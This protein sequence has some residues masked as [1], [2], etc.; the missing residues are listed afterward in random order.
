MR[1]SIK[2]HL[3]WLCIA[4]G[5]PLWINRTPN[6]QKLSVNPRLETDVCTVYN[7]KGI[8]VLSSV[9][10]VYQHFITAVRDEDCIPSI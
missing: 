6:N 5:P 3:L 2:I 8:S 7:P 4:K 9:D 1:L 10:I